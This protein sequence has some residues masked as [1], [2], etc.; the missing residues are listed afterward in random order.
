MP[1]L[2]DPRNWKPSDVEELEDAAWEIV[3]SRNNRTVV[4]GP[5]AGK[6]E[7]LAQRACYL[8]QT[9]T[10]R[11]PRKILA[12]SFK[13][14]AAGNLKDRVNQRCGPDYSRRFDSFTFDAFAKALLDRFRLA[15]P[16]QWRPSGDY[17]INLD[18]YRTIPAFLNSLPA[19][20][21]EIATIFELRTIPE[22]T[23]EKDH[24]VG[25]PLPTDGIE[26]FDAVTWATSK[27]WKESL[28]ERS[29]LSF[30]MIGRLVELLVRFNP[31]ICKAIRATYSH[32][33]L[34]EFQDTTHVQY[35]LV[36]T[37]FLGS[38]NVLTAVGDNKQQIMR[39]AMALEDPFGKFETDFQAQRVQ[40]IRNYRSSHQLVG[41]QHQIALTVDE[42]TR[43][44]ESKITEEYGQEACVV[45]E[46]P[47]VA[48]E[49]E[50]LA[51]LIATDISQRDLVPRDVA[52]LVRQKSSEYADELK[53]AF[54]RAGIIVRDEGELQDVLAER[55]VNMIVTFLR[56]GSVERAGRYWA[57]CSEIVSRLW[58]FEPDD[59]FGGR[60]MQTE[61]AD[62]HLR[63]N[64]SM[65]PRP[66][67]STEIRK[68]IDDVLEFLGEEKIKSTYPQYSQGDWYDT[69]IEKTSRYL[70][71]SWQR[72][73][74]WSNALDDFEGKNS[75]PLMTIHK[76]KGLEHHTVIFLALDDRAW[77]SF[78]NDPQEARSTFFVAFS[79]AKHRVIFTYCEERGGNSEI[80]SLYSI[81]RT[82][83]VPTRC[84]S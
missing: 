69:V 35:D 75:L 37:L 41:I 56:F 18:T 25:F 40:L 68:I 74:D 33:L 17:E 49:A 36:R 46:F 73:Q 27:W 42:E 45:L 77:W 39:W 67:S 78:R 51:Q 55:I 31:R 65:L 3:R 44:T 1:F 24:V 12:I 59:E 76:S 9:G 72:C 30:S 10:I 28:Q 21:P 66:N 50:Y 2:N 14:D 83:G 6:T 58:G 29:R 43:P 71:Q 4:A 7:L 16:E 54:L 64:R 81:L 63:L 20:P 38:P 57:E 79:R 22:R 53:P 23:F 70:F 11:S 62:S 48:K 61:L 80:A 13:R 26:V 52:I 32:V 82:A 19:P 34:D 84:V 8:L 15:L 60:M 5:G 47:T